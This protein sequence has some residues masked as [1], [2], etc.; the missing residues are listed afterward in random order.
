MSFLAVEQF[1]AER[2]LS[3][4]PEKTRITHIDGGFDFLGMNVR[5]YHGRLL[6]K[7]SKGSV[8]RF[9]RK[10]RDVVKANATVRQD[11][12]IR[13]LNPLIRGWANYHCHVVSKRIFSKISC[14]IWRCLWRW[15]RRRHPNKGAR[16]VRRKY[17]QTV[18]A[19]HW[20]FGTKTGVTL[21]SGKPELLL[22]YDIVSTPIRRH[23]K[24]KAAAN[25][26]D[27]QWESYFEERLGLAMMDSLRGRT[28]LIRLWLDQERLCPVCRQPI[29]KSSGWRLFHLD[30]VI[31]GGTNGIR[32]LTM[33]HPDCHGIARGRW[34]SVVKPAPTTGA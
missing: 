32:N 23:R 20:V 24:I 11:W 17:F 8:Q 28:R 34:F 19:R 31:D 12:L 1:L 26:F 29:T 4:S 30:R 13:M 5:K 27:P 21:S 15:A 14:A 7:P 2:G 3:L 10:L 6:I 33:L 18:G 22:L 25:P 16:W 9:L